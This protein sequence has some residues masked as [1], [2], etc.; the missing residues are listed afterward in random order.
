MEIGWGIGRGFGLAE[1]C[2]G[3]GGGKLQGSWRMSL[4]EKAPLDV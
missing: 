1:I 2:G 3:I 4:K